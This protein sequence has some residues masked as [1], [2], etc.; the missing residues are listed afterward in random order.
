M[1]YFD[2]ANRSVTRRS[3]GSSF[4]KE[5]T[6]KDLIPVKDR[7][8]RKA[9]TENSHFE[10]KGELEKKVND[11]RLNAYKG[12][13]NRTQFL[14]E[15]YITLKNDLMK[16]IMRH[17]CVESLVVDEEPVMENLKNIFDVVDTQVE[18]IGGFEGIKQI[19]INTKNPVLNEMVNIC[20]TMAKKVADRVLHEELDC[21][22]MKDEDVEEFDY[23]KKQMGV[24]TIVDVVKDKVLN[25]VK[26]EQKISQEKDDMMTEIKGKLE[27]IEAPVEE[28]MDFIFGQEKVE[29]ISLFSSMMRKEYKSILESSAATIYEAKCAKDKKKAVCE[30]DEIDINDIDIHE[31]EDYLDK[32]IMKASDMRMTDA[33]K[34]TDDDDDDD[35]EPDSLNE[36]IDDDDDDD[37]EVEEIMIK[38]SVKPLMDK[39]MEI[40]ESI[41]E[42]Y[43][44]GQVDTYENLLNEMATC[45]EE[46]A[47][48]CKGPKKAKACKE[49]ARNVEVSTE[50]RC[51]KK[52]E[53]TEIDGEDGEV[54]MELDEK[55]PQEKMKPTEAD[56]RSTSEPTTEGARL[57]R[58]NE[59]LK[60]YNEKQAAKLI[61]KRD[62]EKVR[63]NLEKFVAQAKTVAD[64]EYLEADANMGVQELSKAKI[65]YPDGT[66]K[67]EEQIK[68]IKSDYKKMLEKRK[69]EIKAQGVTEAFAARVDAVCDRLDD[70]ITAHEDALYEANISM[71]SEYDGKTIILPLIESIDVNLSNIKFAYKAKVVCESLLSMVDKIENE[72]DAVQL[73]EM[74]QVNIASIDSTKSMIEGNEEVS[75][76]KRDL[77]ENVRT[78]LS[79]IDSRV[80]TII[81]GLEDRLDFEVINEA[82]T[83]ID[84]LYDVKRNKS[85]LEQMNSDRMELVMAEA[86]TNYT[87]L[88]T[89]HTLNLLK[90]DKE[91]VRQ[92]ARNN[93]K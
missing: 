51:S 27:D 83:L 32:N 81:D 28:A 63:T 76:Y 56:K 46:F 87:I 14:S 3:Y 67:F 79:D 26:D 10:L 92:M 68:W 49:F 66:E 23:N 11:T 86:I 89:F 74:I 4:G 13:K 35:D 82:K 80:N 48:G 29:E 20:E 33:D 22:K 9:L 21:F 31:D 7:G 93:I 58:F 78:Q 73:Q 64:I 55:K 36:L 41:I 91:S 15:G 30:D 45:M 44:N 42:S 57:D 2:K 24:D 40:G 18:N 16:D 52:K 19:G 75:E 43:D 65:S 5:I 72:T 85:L 77:L 53:V 71:E 38:E 39:F 61:S 1:S 47:P 62:F 59:R 90:F 60:A 37:D 6:R 8:N 50:A 70:E 25:V 54:V 12:E 88:E 34:D 69:K 84:E 17:I